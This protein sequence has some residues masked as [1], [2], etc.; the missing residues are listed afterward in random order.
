MAPLCFIYEVELRKVAEEHDLG[1]GE[2]PTEKVAF[3]LIKP[4]YD[5]QWNQNDLYVVYYLF[6]LNDMEDVATV[7]KDVKR[8]GAHGHLFCSALHIDLCY[9]AFALKQI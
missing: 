3:V 5:I 2:N 8:P 4:P 6:G 1:V 9:K 7:L